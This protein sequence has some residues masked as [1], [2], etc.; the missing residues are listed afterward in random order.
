MNSTYL[1][2]QVDID[3]MMKGLEK[4][5]GGLKEF[6]QADVATLERLLARYDGVIKQ[7]TIVNLAGCLQSAGTVQFI[8]KKCRLLNPKAC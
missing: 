3:E 6:C 5:I 8:E 7:L 2:K 1:Y 4:K